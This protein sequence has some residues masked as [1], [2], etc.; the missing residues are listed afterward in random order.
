MADVPFSKLV[1][2]VEARLAGFPVTPLPAEPEKSQVEDLLFNTL[3]SAKQF[4]DLT[5]DWT[6]LRSLYGRYRAVPNSLS[7][8]QKAS[9]K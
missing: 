7:D 6:F 4:D 9:T 8:D 1:F 2:K 3:I 5:N